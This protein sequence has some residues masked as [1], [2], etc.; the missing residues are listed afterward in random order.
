MLIRL[1]LCDLEVIMATDGPYHWIKPEEIS[2]IDEKEVFSKNKTKWFKAWDGCVE[3]DFADTVLA[4]YYNDCVS[5]RTIKLDKGQCIPRELDITGIDFI[6]VAIY[7]ICNLGS[8]YAACVFTSNKK[9]VDEE[10]AQPCLAL[11]VDAFEKSEPF[12]KDILRDFIL[13]VFKYGPL[14]SAVGSKGGFYQV[15]NL[16]QNLFLERIFKEGYITLSNV[17]GRLFADGRRLI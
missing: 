7:L 1:A 14:W 6:K 11:M 5:L 16:E 9:L 3:D 17:D 10:S 4:D 8:N 13:E 12:V 15:L 2:G